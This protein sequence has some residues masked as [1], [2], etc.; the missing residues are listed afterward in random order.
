MSASVKNDQKLPVDTNGGGTDFYSPMV[1]SAQD[2]YP[3]GMLMPGRSF[4]STEYRF[5]FNGMENDNEVKG[6]G[7]SL[8][9]NARIYNSRLGRF[10]SIDPMAF[11]FANMSHYSFAANSPV[12]LIDDNGNEPAR[13]QAGTIQQ[14]VAQ[15]SQNKKTTAQ[16]IMNYIQNN[17]DAVRYVYT[18]DIGWVDLQHYFGAINYGQMAMDALEVVAGPKFMQDS[19]F[20]EGADKSYYSYEDLPSNAFGGE[21]P[22]YDVTTKYSPIEKGDVPVTKPKTGTRLY[23][24]VED[25]FQSAGAT[26]PENAPNWNQ[27]PLDDQERKRLPKN[28]TNKDLNSG[29]YVPQNHSEKPY[30]LKDFPAAESSIESTKK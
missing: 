4:S 13:N 8:D 28:F 16:D 29:K 21:A 22:V 24:A 9:F 1:L 19:F 26:N 2:Y 3:F 27:I 30:N 10:L 18:E 15:W 5:G 14:A 25:H 20:G 12:L 17:K 23:N 11:K 7:K 6:V